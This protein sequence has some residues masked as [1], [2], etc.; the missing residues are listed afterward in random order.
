MLGEVLSL[1]RGVAPLFVHDFA[2][3]ADEAMSLI[4]SWISVRSAFWNQ[5]E[6]DSEMRQVTYSDFN[7]VKSSSPRAQ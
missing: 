3:E 1:G 2:E 4:A 7:T 6:L 5:A